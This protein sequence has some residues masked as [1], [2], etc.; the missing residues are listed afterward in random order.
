M[1]VLPVDARSR[2]RT[3]VMTK[4]EITK[5]TS[6]PTNPPENPGTFEWKRTTRSTATARNP[7][8]SGLKGRSPGAVPDSSPE[9]RIRSSVD[10]E[11][12]WAAPAIT[13]AICPSLGPPTS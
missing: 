13:S 3:P 10:R 11:S 5:K 4:P 6:T 7:S 12:G 2:K 1:E 9:A 8:T